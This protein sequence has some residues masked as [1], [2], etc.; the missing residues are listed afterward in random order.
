LCIRQDQQDDLP[1][2]QMLETIREF[3][4]EQLA[5]SGEL[6]ALQ[7]QHATHFLS[8]ATQL[9]PD[10]DGPRGNDVLTTL[11]VEHPNLR[12]ALMWSCDTG[13]N[14]L[15]LQLSCALWKFWQVHAHLREGLSWLRRTL[16]ASR[17]TRS[18]WRW[19][20]LYAAG[21]FA[22]QLGEYDRATEYS[23]ELLEQAQAAEDAFYTGLALLTLGLIAY[24]QGAQH[25]AR[26]RL[27]AALSLF[28][29]PDHQHAEAMVR[30]FLADIHSIQG[31]DSVA[32]DNA[33]RAMAIWQARGDDWG[34]AIALGHKA[35]AYR[36]RGDHDQAAACYL[37]SLRLRAQM[38]DPIMTADCLDEWSVMAVKANQLEW[39]ARL[40]GAGESL[41]ERLGTPR[42]LAHENTIQ[43]ATDTMRNRLGEN[44]FT[45]AFATGYAS[46]LDQIITEATD[47]VADRAR[48]SEAGEPNAA[49]RRVGLTRR[50]VEV[51]RLLAEGGSDQEI[52][53]AL[54]VSRR[55]VT[56]HVTSILTKLQVS[57]R[58]AAATRAVRAELI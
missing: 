53:Y 4:L 38:A 28:S 2:F 52:A 32:M 27:E 31:D 41:R 12:A 6:Q 25:D 3:G 9:R 14:Q 5:A 22:R 37:E 19:Q 7:R 43:Q 58:T 17:G 49:A 45:I 33:N 54:C 10:I 1:R 24:D 51:L 23:E 34:I 56:S 21:S 36:S 39:A 57:S 11:D 8:L 42:S 50:E 15:G 55:T 35:N 30:S 18:S 13:E 20:S 16:A 29:Q 46:T 40:F 47:V 26:S 48:R 44:G